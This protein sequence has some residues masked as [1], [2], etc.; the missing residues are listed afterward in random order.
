MKYAFI[1]QQ[2]SRYSLQSLRRVLHDSRSGYYDW[3]RR[4][5]SPRTRS[6]DALLGHIRTVHRQ[7]RQAYGAKK[8]WRY[9]NAIG[10]P[11]GQHR[12]ARLRKRAGLRLNANAAFT[13][14]A[15]TESGWATIRTCI[16]SLKLNNCRHKRQNNKD[17]GQ[18]TF[19][20]N[21]IALAH[22]NRGLISLKKRSVDVQVR[23]PDWSVGLVKL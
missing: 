23:Q 19:F 10:I 18:T 21:K 6:D 2:R 12:G 3:L 15:P 11:C 20:N 4:A 7:H 5:P 9:V 1:R 17:K 22:I 14:H 13:T 8:T 16:G